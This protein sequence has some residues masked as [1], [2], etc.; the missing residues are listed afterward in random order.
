MPSD[1]LADALFAKGTLHT[2]LGSSRRRA[3]HAQLHEIVERHFGPS[4]QAAA[5]GHQRQ[6]VELPLHTKAYI[7]AKATGAAPASLLGGSPSGGS[8]AAA[9]PLAAEKLCLFCGSPVSDP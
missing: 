1:A 6:R 5:G 2:A 7:L 4:A 8:R 3:F 9:Q